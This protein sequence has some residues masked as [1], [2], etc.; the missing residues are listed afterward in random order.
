MLCIK[1]EYVRYC[2]SG[3]QIKQI[4]HNVCVCVCVCILRLD[5]D[6]EV[7]PDVS[8]MDYGKMTVLRISLINNS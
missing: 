5:R 6:C 2:V 4:S 3:D 7:P 1:Y 8:E